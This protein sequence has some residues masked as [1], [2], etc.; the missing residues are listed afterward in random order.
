M[1]GHG[2]SHTKAQKGFLF[3]LPD[4]RG[5]LLGSASVPRSNVLVASVVE[6]DDSL[7]EAVELPALVV[8]VF[9]LILSCDC[10]S[11]SFVGDIIRNVLV[12]SSGSMTSN[13]PA[14]VGDAGGMLTSW[15]LTRITSSSLRRM[16]W[17][18]IDT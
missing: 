4:P 1:V 9:P 3:R 8:E 15:P 16:L 13:S 7:V 10:A 18:S 14:R 2:T 17:P 6:A 11:A 5:V 12:V